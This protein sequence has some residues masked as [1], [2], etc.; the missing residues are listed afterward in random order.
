MKSTEINGDPRLCWIWQQVLESPGAFNV[1]VSDALK[2]LSEP[3]T[4][5]Y[6]PR[7]KF[8]YLK[9]ENATTFPEYPHLVAKIKNS[10]IGISAIISLIIYLWNGS[11]SVVLNYIKSLLSSFCDR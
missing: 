7:S 1:P 5:L 11:L 2:T 6:S 3:N 9:S 8:S 4:V 10:Y